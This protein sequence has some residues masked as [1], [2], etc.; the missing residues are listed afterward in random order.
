MNLQRR[1]H[2]IESNLLFGTNILTAIVICIFWFLILMS[3]VAHAK[4]PDV[5]IQ[6]S[7]AHIQTLI[8]AS[9]PS[10]ILLNE[11]ADNIFRVNSVLFNAAVP[12]ITISGDLVQANRSQH[13]PV[14]ATAEIA[15]KAHNQS[16][17]IQ[18][19]LRDLRVITEEIPYSQPITLIKAWFLS[20]S[21]K[22]PDL[23]PIV[24]PIETQFKLSGSEF[25]FRSRESFGNATAE[26]V[27]SLKTTEQRID[28]TV[29]EAKM[30]RGALIVALNN[31]AI[32]P[33]SKSLN[34]PVEFLNSTD[35]SIYLNGKFLAVFLNKSANKINIPF[36]LENPRGKIDGH[37]SSTLLGEK[38]WYIEFQG[39]KPLAGNISIDTKFVWNSKLDFDSAIS[40]GAQGQI[41]AHGDPGPGGGCGVRPGVRLN[42]STR[43]IGLIDVSSSTDQV[44]FSLLAASQTKGKIHYKVDRVNICG[45]VT[46][47]PYQGNFDVAIPKTP[48]STSLTL[49][50]LELGHHKNK[51]IKSAIQ[52]V[53]TISDGYLISFEIA[54]TKPS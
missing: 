11:P 29:S 28:M 52:H 22:K 15:I 39:N 26:V 51:V 46:K 47:G 20:L 12:S 23:D 4:H 3:P 33:N 24:I 17:L 14:I 30:Q 50:P 40:L 41:H 7:S 1:S 25:N 45:V 19:K 43:L 48:I 21:A 54:L 16:I 5:A 32:N 9:M 2:T 31:A 35:S 44:Q 18:P 38:E 10:E 37:S 34:Y 49:L 13:L 42:G 6:I 36:H 53:T 27:A 8:E